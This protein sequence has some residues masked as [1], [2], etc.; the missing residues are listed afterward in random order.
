MA[1]CG[2]Q[3]Y[4]R[5]GGLDDSDSKGLTLTKGQR[6]KAKKKK[7]KKKLIRSSFHLKCFLLWY[8]GLPA[9]RYL[10]QH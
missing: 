3:A 6:K 7:K 1:S 10:L 8:P 5:Q 9:A 4:R 2:V